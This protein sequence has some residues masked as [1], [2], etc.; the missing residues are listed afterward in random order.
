MTAPFVRELDQFYGLV[1][2][3]TELDEVPVSVELSEP[4]LLLTYPSL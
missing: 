2:V 4:E 1:L 3:P